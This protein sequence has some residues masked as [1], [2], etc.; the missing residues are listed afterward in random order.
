MDVDNHAVRVLCLRVA[1]FY[2]LSGNLE[3]RHYKWI[4]DRLLAGDVPKAFFE[5]LHEPVSQLVKTGAELGHI[6]VV[7]DDYKSSR[8]DLSRMGRL[9][10]SA[11]LA[12][13]REYIP[14]I[15]TGDRGLLDWLTGQSDVEP[16]YKE[17]ER[18]I[19]VRW[20]FWRG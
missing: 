20:V 18:R 8:V 13:C 15:Y 17:I 6:E 10:L 19:Q 1:K 4:R 14:A 2:S 16:E 11:Y 5:M 3:M 12:A 9:R 7:A